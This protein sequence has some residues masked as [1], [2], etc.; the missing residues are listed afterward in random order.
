MK[1]MKKKYFSLSD[2]FTMIWMSGFVPFVILSSFL[3]QGKD[4]R[5]PVAV[6]TILFIATMVFM[7]NSFEKDD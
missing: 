5:I 3:R 2:I 7:Y 6:A 4:F 1:E